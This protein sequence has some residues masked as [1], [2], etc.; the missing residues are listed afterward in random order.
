M[1]LHTFSFPF[2]ERS[3]LRMFTRKSWDI[4]LSKNLFLCAITRNKHII[5]FSQSFQKK[6]IV[7]KE[8]VEN[9]S[10]KNNSISNPKGTLIFTWKA[11]TVTNTKIMSK[12]DLLRQCHLS[13]AVCPGLQVELTSLAA[14][15]SDSVAGDSRGI[16]LQE[17]RNNPL[18]Y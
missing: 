17:I 6:K 18:C 11:F 8:D 1:T 13:P 10:I 14:L 16:S 9:Y 3:S 15:T 12:L 4:N 5:S 2:K 7:T